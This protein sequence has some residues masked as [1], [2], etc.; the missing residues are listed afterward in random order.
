MDSEEE[1]LRRDFA[2]SPAKLS[3]QPLGPLRDF[4]R[5]RVWYPQVGRNAWHSTW[6]T[7]Y[8]RE[9]FSFFRKDLAT[10][11]ERKRVQGT[12]FSILAVDAC[13]LSFSKSMIL[14]CEMDRS[15]SN[16]L[17]ECVA[18]EV[19]KKGVSKALKS[20]TDQNV[21]DFILSFKMGNPKANLDALPD[22]PPK[23]FNSTSV[24]TDYYLNWT[25]KDIN[26]VNPQFEILCQALQ[27]A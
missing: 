9:L 5:C 25:E 2:L 3:Q 22:V 12:T 8:Y 20:I 7:L 6:S 11:A 21:Y 24:G 17:H 18:T 16:R 4:R 10:M 13:I 19:S 23:R 15:R 27:Q 1:I 14:L 26:T